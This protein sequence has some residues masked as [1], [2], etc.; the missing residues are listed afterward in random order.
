[1]NF[2]DRLSNGWTMA[3][4]SFKVLKENKQLIIFPILSGISLILVI[5]SFF[6]GIL[7]ANGWDIDNMET[8]NP[9]VIYG[10]IF[11]FYI[12]NYFVIV[13]FNMALVHCT[14]L[15]FRGEEVTVRAGLQFS[16]SRIGAIFSWAIFAAVVGTILKAIQ[17][18]SG[19]VGK[20]IT[21]II[22]IVWG[23]A[24][25]FVVPII[26]YENVGPLEAFKRSSKM[27]KE[28]WGQSLGATFSFG[29]I[30]IIG[31]LIVAIPL[32]LVGSLIHPAVGIVFA[33][34]G[35][36]AVVAIISAA[37]VIFISAVYHNINGDPVAHFNQQAID[38]L[39]V[40]K[41]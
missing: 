36:F 31:I 8:E 1:M 10:T 22:G 7:A 25:F 18:N 28:K 23:I 27:M 34:L 11:L 9:F 35:A 13:F 2:F 3:M 5:G 33:S 19:V 15:Y 6:T 32:Y 24:T 40:H 38:N 21:G 30:Q 41:D 14:R 16:F 17:E 26:A 39:F 29:L 4:N 37:E 20:V 12:V